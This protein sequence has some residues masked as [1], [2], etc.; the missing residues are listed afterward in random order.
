MR[1]LLVAHGYPPDS[2]GGV[3]QHAQGLAEA[4]VAAGHAVHVLT[5]HHLPGRPQGE[6]ETGPAVDPRL[7]K[8]RVSKIAYRWEGVDSLDAMYACTPMADGI[9]KFLAA[10]QADGETFDVAHVH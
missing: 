9:R 2:V 7:G 4:L 8:P 6:H 5:R 10:R 3:E 1:I